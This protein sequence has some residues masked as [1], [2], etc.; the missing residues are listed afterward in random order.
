M[1]KVFITKYALT[2]GIIEKEVKISVC[3]GPIGV[4]SEYAKAKDDYAGYFIGNDA[5]YELDKAIDKAE[6][7]RD[8]KILSL[9]RQITKLEGMS[10]KAYKK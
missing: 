2:K 7:M 5:F 6:K 3:E 10:F 4:F 9:K 1:V 8:R